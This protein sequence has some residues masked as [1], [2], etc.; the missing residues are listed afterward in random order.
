[1]LSLA[2]IE[3]T[4]CIVKVRRQLNIRLCQKDTFS[5]DHLR[6]FFVHPHTGNQAT[7]KIFLKNFVVKVSPK[8]LP[9]QR[10]QK[11]VRIPQYQPTIRVYPLKSKLYHYLW[12]NFDQMMSIL[13]M[14]VQKIQKNIKTMP[15]PWQPSPKIMKILNFF[16]FSAKKLL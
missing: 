14:C 10:G 8:P 7:C 11:S 5:S 2:S 6:N 1:M 4:I 13:Y 12:P 16:K 9:W 3:A 15:L